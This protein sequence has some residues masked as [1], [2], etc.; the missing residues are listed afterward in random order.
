VRYAL[1]SDVHGNLESLAAV[2]ARLA[3]EDELLSLGDVVGYGPNPNE[4]VARISARVSEA[5]LGNHDVAAIDSYGLSFFNDAAREAIE[6][7][8]SVLTEDSA[9]WLDSLSYEVR[10]PEYLLVHGAPVDYFAYI[11]DKAAAVRAFAAT[12]APLV[13]VGHTHVADYYACAPDGEILHEHRQSGGELELR[14]GF[15]YIVNVGSV[16]QPRD[17]NPDASFAFFEPAARRV[18]WE[19][20]P[21]EV[22]RVRAKIDAANL[23]AT[24]GKRLA[25]G[26]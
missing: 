17:L 6:W 16:G 3:P 15:R 21:Y 14:D 23:P 13:F 9:A 11:F 24:L 22:A 20:V 19:R 4:C 12:D 25:S 26:R 1:L 5:V 10:R 18:V 7:T 8:Q 2:L